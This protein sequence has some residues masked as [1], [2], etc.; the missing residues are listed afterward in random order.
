MAHITWESLPIQGEM[1]MESIS[2]NTSSMKAIG[3]T[4]SMRAKD[5][6]SDRRMLM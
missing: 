3:L 4:I 2:M 1:V 5:C 6:L